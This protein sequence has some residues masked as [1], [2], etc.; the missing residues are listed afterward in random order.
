MAAILRDEPPELSESGRNISPALDRIVRHCLEKD[1]DQRFQSARDIA[2]NLV[3]QSSSPVLSGA[4]E[5]APIRY[6][7]DSGAARTEE[8][9]WVAVLPFKYSGANADLAA[10]ADGISEDIVTGL[11]RFSY[12]QGDRAQFDFA[13]RQ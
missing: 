8:G 10:L 6:A 13:L 4:R 2:F 12:L 5:A 11:S 3:E 9:F 1:R 7:D